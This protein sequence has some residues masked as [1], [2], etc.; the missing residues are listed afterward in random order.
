MKRIFSLMLIVLLLC[1]CT[2]PQEE[3]EPP[4]SAEPIALD[5]LTLECSAPAGS[6]GTF[7]AAATAFGETLR[8]ALEAEGVR[9]ARVI[10]SFS[11]VDAATADALETGGVTLGLMGLSGALVEKGTVLLALSR[12]IEE[13]SCGLL[14][15]GESE[16]GKQLAWRTKT[17]PLTAEEWSRAAIGGVESDHVLI[18]AAKQLLDEQAGYSLDGY[19]AYATAEELLAAVQRGE[20]DAAIVRAEDTEEFW[21]LTESVA[22]YEGAM[23]LASSTPA[24]Q[25]ET[26]QQALVRALCAAAETEEGKTLLGKY[27]CDGFVTVTEEEIEA[28]GRLA[29]WEEME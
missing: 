7:P 26:A 28:M 1:G 17:A 19:Y 22:L 18:A 4:A 5:V 12:N 11:R 3:M 25:S 29:I 15:A 24:L 14:I 21:A 27:D 13:P 10:V 9:V 20:V 2:A 6:D 23:V 8:L 16:Y